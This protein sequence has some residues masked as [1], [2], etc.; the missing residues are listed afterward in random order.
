MKWIVPALGITALTACASTTARTT[1]ARVA[2]AT[3]KCRV[4]RETIILN[5]NRSYRINPAY[6]TLENSNHLNCVEWEL[7]DCKGGV[8]MFEP[9]GCIMTGLRDPN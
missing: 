4:P 9:M 8:K 7:L 1:E 2:A 3:Q 6:D 5:K